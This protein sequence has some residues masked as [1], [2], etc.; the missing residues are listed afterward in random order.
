MDE[1]TGGNCTVSGGFTTEQV[2]YIVAIGSNGELPVSFKVV[3]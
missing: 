2:K 3:K 1:I